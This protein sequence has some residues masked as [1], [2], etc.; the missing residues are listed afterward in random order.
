MEQIIAD[1]A[2][3]LGKETGIQVQEAQRTP[4]KINKNRPIPQHIIEKLRN[5]R[6]KKKILKGAQDKRSVNL[7]G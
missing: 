4:I 1:N 6:D 7:Q 3:N 2:P 5:V